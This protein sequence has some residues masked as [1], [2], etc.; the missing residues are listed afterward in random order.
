MMKDEETFCCQT[1]SRVVSN[2]HVCVQIIYK[3]DYTEYI[4]PIKI[5]CD[6]PSC[7]LDHGPQPSL[8]C[9]VETI[10]RTRV[11]VYHGYSCPCLTVDGSGA[12]HL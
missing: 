4:F 3:F 11:H 1:G 2:I 10:D 12:S 7:L 9:H 8:E 6:D 5:R